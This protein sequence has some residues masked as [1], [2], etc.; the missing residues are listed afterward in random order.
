MAERKRKPANKSKALTAGSTLRFEEPKSSRQRPPKKVVAPVHPVS[1]FVRFLRENAIVSL[2]IG[3]VLATQMQ[4]L[5]K[6]LIASFIDPLFKLLFGQTL[7]QRTFTLHFH[8]R[9][10]NFQWGAFV[11]ILLD[12]LF[13]AAAVYTIIKI[14]ALDKLDKPKS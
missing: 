1:G 2:A 5:I 3:F 13:V 12:F 6:Q 9:S 14:L 10:A 11:Y 7:S 4:S 8:A